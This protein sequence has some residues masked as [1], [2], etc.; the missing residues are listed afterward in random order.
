MIMLGVSD[1]AVM[2]RSQVYRS[3]STAAAVVEL[4]ATMRMFYTRTIGSPDVLFMV[5]LASAREAYAVTGSSAPHPQRDNRAQ[6]LAAEIYLAG[7]L[8]CDASFVPARVPPD[9]EHH[10]TLDLVKQEMQLSTR[11]CGVTAGRISLFGVTLKG[12]IVSGEFVLLNT[13]TKALLANV[14][15]EAIKKPDFFRDELPRLACQPEPDPGQG[16]DE[17]HALIDQ[18]VELQVVIPL[19]G[20]SCAFVVK[21]NKAASRAEVCSAETGNPI[22]S[23]GLGCLQ[24]IIR[25]G[26]NQ[27]NTSSPRRPDGNSSCFL[28]LLPIVIRQNS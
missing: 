12:P 17:S 10:Y 11:V 18:A 7:S 4:A 3:G 23:V 22:G 26:L 1:G 15:E 16:R 19:I 14:P 28:E 5:L 8:L 2:D 20:G 25:A 27:A 13:S 24:R 6:G 21:K 9:C